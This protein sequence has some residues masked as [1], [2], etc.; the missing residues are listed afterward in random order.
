MPTLKGLIRKYVFPKRKPAAWFY[1]DFAQ[2]ESQQVQGKARFTLSTADFYPCLTDRTT[3]T[4]LDRHYV[5]HP[6]WAARIIART[7]PRLHIDISSTLH[8]STILSAFVTTEFYDYRPAEIILDNF[9]AKKADLNNLSFADNSVESLS[10]MHTV[11]H[12]GLGRYGDPVDY[13]G[14]LKAM[15]ELARVLAPGGNLLFVTPVGKANEIHF[16]AHR[17]Y[18]ATAISEAFKSLGLSLVEFSYIPQHS[19]P[20]LEADVQSFTTADRYGCGCFWWTKKS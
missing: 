7:A 14:D 19:G 1:Q 15:R 18:T 9:F 4:P 13:D 10:C 8:F 12:I 6:A 5:Y 16:N 11:E 3:T 17:I 20:M 2:L